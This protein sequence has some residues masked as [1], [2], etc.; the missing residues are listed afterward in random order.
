MMTDDAACPWPRPPEKIDTDIIAG[1]GWVLAAQ[2][3]AHG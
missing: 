3:A 1:Y 2:H